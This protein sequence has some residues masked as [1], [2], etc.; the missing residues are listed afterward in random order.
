[1]VSEDEYERYRLWWVGQKGRPP[2]PDESVEFERGRAIWAEVWSAVPALTADREQPK[3]YQDGVVDCASW[4]LARLPGLLSAIWL[5]WAQDLM[6]DDGPNEDSSV[7][8]RALRSQTQNEYLV[9]MMRKGVRIAS[10]DNV[11]SVICQLKTNR[12]N[13]A[14]MRQ[15]YRAAEALAALLNVI[16]ELAR[17][18]TAL[19]GIVGLEHPQALDLPD[20]SKAPHD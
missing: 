16:P 8:F 14:Q 13:D 11:E 10:L 9:A 18:R 20:P 3:T 2:L 7:R 15:D 4:T 12:A 5:E 1:M 19:E 17:L 6:P